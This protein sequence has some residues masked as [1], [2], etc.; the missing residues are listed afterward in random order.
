LRAVHAIIRG[1]KIQNQL[2]GRRLEAAHELL[3]EHLMEKPRFFAP[4][5]VFPPAQRRTAAQGLVA[6]GRCLP[7][8]VVAQGVVI[9]EVLVPKRQAV[10]ALLQQTLQRMGDAVRVAWIG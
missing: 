7:H 3:E 8:H 9:I 5:P 6:S 10:Q 4:G 1:V 2:F